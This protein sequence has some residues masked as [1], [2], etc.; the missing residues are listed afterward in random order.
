[1]LCQVSLIG[2][3]QSGKNGEFKFLIFFNRY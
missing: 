2:E 1:M 3:V